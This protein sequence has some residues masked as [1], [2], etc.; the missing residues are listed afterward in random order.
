MGLT[1]VAKAA[2][3]CRTSLSKVLSGERSRVSPEACKR[4]VELAVRELGKE[5]AP[6]LDD[7][8]FWQPAKKGRRG[9][10]STS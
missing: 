7:L 2:D 9:A 6:K 5:K 3:V 8:L 4:L 1:E 10:R